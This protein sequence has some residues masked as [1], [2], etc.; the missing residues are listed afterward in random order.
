MPLW[1]TTKA[2]W[3]AMTG[4]PRK[5]TQI[6]A[7]GSKAKYR[8]HLQ[9]ASAKDQ[10]KASKQARKEAKAASG[11]G[12]ALAKVLIVLVGA[13]VV[14][15]LVAEAVMFVAAHLV[16]TGAVA[17]MLGALAATVLGWRSGVLARQ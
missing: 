15:A 5:A 2:G 7:R 6:M 11:S 8:Q 3:T 17:A 1:R 13:A 9:A 16:Q 10:L 14:Y 4:R 12:E